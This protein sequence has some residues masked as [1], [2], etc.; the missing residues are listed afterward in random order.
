M[1]WKEP[2]VHSD[3]IFLS[4]LAT[5]D[6]DFPIDEWDKLLLQSEMTLNM[7]RTTRCNPEL[8]II[9]I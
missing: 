3:Y 9:Y 1:L 8:S 7:F 2:Y 4:A 6:P 5:C